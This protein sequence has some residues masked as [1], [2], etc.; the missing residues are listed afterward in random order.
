M[1][2]IAD[3]RTPTEQPGDA[4]LSYI[5]WLTARY[6]AGLLR[7]AYSMDDD[8]ALLAALLRSDAYPE[9]APYNGPDEPPDWMLWFAAIITAEAARAEMVNWAGKEA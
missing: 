2:S 5:A 3:N 4:P 1:Q 9:I 8:M 7:P 6:R